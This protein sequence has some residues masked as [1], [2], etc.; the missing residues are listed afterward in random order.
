MTTRAF[1]TGQ[2]SQTANATVI[3]VGNST[4]NTTVNATSFS[5][6]A[7]NANNFGGSSTTTWGNYITGNAA[8]AYTNA[9]TYSANASNLGNGTVG[10]ARLASGTANSTTILYGNSVWATVSAGT[11]VVTI[12]DGTTLSV[13]TDATDTAIQINTQTAGTLTVNTSGTPVNGQKFVVR[14]KSTNVQTFSFNTI[15]AGSTDLSLPTAS[16]GS[17]KTDY[18]GFVYDSTATKWHMIAKNFGF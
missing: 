9:T 10:T 5:G 12:T 3:S 18:M 8:T 6:T 14:L 11:R 17:S 7:N 16:S 2:I 4:V 15:F 1:T 13:N